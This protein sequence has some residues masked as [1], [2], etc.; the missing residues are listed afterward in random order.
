MAYNYGIPDGTYTGKPTTASCYEKDGR[1]I[2]DVNFAV[3]DPN[4][5]AWYK[6]DNGY[7]WEVRKRHWLTSADGGFNEKT[8]EGLKEWAKGWQPRSLDDFWWFQNPDENGTPFGNLIAIGEV[9]LKFQTDGQGNQTIWVH[10]PDR[11][12]SGGR[13]AYV[14]DG[15]SSDRAAMMAKWG[16]RAKALFAATPKKVG[17]GAPA[18]AAPKPAQAAPAAGGGVAPSR[19]AA[20]PATPS[21]PAGGAPAKADPW[22]EYPKT[23]DGAFAYFCSLLGEAYSGAKHDEKWFALFDAAAQGKDPDEFTQEDVQGLFQTIKD[24]MAG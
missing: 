11:P 15:A 23:C 22:A 13:K 8:I 12:K 4:T 7:D 18:Q 10:D 21:R 5:G 24:G 9:E 14:P 6:K 19:P 20:A 17:T 3:K 2:L 1:L 16:T